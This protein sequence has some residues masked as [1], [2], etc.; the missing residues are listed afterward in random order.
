MTLIA[1]YI[2][3][4]FIV[5]EGERLTSN[6]ACFW[7]DCNARDDWGVAFDSLIIQRKEV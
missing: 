7:E 1:I 3:S 2:V 6:E 4:T 5:N